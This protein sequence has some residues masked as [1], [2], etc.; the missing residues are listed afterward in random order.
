MARYFAALKVPLLLMAGGY[1][2][3]PALG[4]LLP[5]PLGGLVASLGRWAIIGMGGWSIVQSGV[6]GPFGAMWAGPLLV[7]VEHALTAAVVLIMVPWDDKLPLVL[8]ATLIAYVIWAPV[9]L[10]PAWLGGF[11]GLGGAP[12]AASSSLRRPG[13]LPPGSA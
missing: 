10:V 3:L 4:E 9:A 13:H 5:P 6:T 2:A 7:L 12:A 8:A 11:I 1:F